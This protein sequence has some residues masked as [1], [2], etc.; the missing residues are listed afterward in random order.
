MWESGRRSTVGYA[1]VFSEGSWLDMGGERKSRAMRGRCEW[2][3][4][5]PF[6]PLFFFFL[7]LFSLFFINFFFYK[8]SSKL[9]GSPYLLGLTV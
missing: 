7:P 5:L 1:V 3:S 8:L 2:F 4:F 6:F 9:S